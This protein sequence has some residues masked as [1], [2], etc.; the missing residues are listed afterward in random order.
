VRL[1]PQTAGN[2]SQH[3]QFSGVTG[4]FTITNLG[5][6]QYGSD[7]S[8]VLEQGHTEDLWT[9]T[10]GSLGM[11]HQEQSNRPLAGGSCRFRWRGHH[12]WKWFGVADVCAKVR[13][14]S[15]QVGNVK[16]ARSV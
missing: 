8:G 12:K 5:T 9:L 6:G 14:A 1:T 10:P 4:G 16:G 7:Q 2:A 13:S 11:E 3:W 15:E